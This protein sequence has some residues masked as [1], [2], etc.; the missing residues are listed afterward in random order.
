MNAKVEEEEV[1]ELTA[2]KIGL[3]DLSVFMLDSPT[4]YL[5]LVGLDSINRHCYHRGYNH[6]EL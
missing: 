6:R 5:V 3:P 2:N 1:L 4:S